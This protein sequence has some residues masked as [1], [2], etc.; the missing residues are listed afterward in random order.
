M[1]EKKAQMDK[2]FSD[3]MNDMGG[4]GAQAQA[5]LFLCFETLLLLRKQRIASSS[6]HVVMASR[7][8]LPSLRRPDVSARH[9]ASIFDA[10][11]RP[12]QTSL[13]IN[14]S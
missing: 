1:A 2:D 13:Q 9:M 14:S 12:R 10:K 5:A 8:W 6:G 4:L 11:V 7:L 3:M